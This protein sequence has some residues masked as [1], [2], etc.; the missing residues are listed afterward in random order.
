ME[1]APD[2]IRTVSTWCRRTPLFVAIAKSSKTNL[3]CKG[4]QSSVLRGIYSYRLPI[5]IPSDAAELRKNENFSAG[6]AL[7]FPRGN[8]ITGVVLET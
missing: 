7:T 3:G 4:R 1:A 2:L 5:F 8:K 6:P